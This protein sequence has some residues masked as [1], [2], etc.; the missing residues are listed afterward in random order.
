MQANGKPGRTFIF[1][2]LLLILTVGCQ[3]A[4]EVPTI[5]QTP[6]Y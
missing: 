1:V 4:T 3:S 6:T 2:L 5:V